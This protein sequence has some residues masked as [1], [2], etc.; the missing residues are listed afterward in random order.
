MSSRGRGRRSKIMKKS[1]EGVPKSKQKTE[2]V[3]KIQ[4]GENKKRQEFP[5]PSQFGPADGTFSK[6]LLNFVH[7]HEIN[8]A[9]V[10]SKD[11]TKEVEDKIISQETIEKA[12]ASLPEREARII[13]LRYGL[14]GAER[15]LL[16]E[17][18]AK[19]LGLSKERV[20]QLEERALLRMRRVAEK[21]L[22]FDRPAPRS[23]D[24]DLQPGWKSDHKS[25]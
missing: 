4:T 3:P 18:I 11:P 23:A 21:K 2:Q 16:H 6:S 17:E 9:P 15:P 12:L 24:H 13:S 7:A 14:G 8:E 1:H 10:M 22:G 19:E 5:F 20:R 25:L